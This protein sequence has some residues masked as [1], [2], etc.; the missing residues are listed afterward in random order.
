MSTMKSAA[1]LAAVIAGVAA[2]G[3]TPRAPVTFVLRNSHSEE[4]VFNMDRG[5]QPNLFAFRGK[6]PRAKWILMFP[7]HCTASCDAPP[8]DRCPACREPSTARDQLKAQEFARVAPGDEI[9]V[10]W[11]GRVFQYEKTRGRRKGKRRRCECHRTEAAPPG[12]YTVRACGLR[13]TR[14]ATRRSQLQCET[15]EMRLPASGQRIEFD[16]GAPGRRRD[17]VSIVVE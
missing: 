12:V 16:F 14:S 15:A 7:K 11:D 4:L 9:E 6:P 2:G 13:L 5:W 3:C 1:L 10:P 17:R 8:R